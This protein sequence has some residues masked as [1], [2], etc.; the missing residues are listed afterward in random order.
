[1]VTQS[2]SSE[3]SLPVIQRGLYRLVEGKVQMNT[4]QISGRIEYKFINNTK[5]VY[6]EE[7]GT[8]CDDYGGGYNLIAKV[9][10]KSLGLNYQNAELIFEFSPA[11]KGNIW[12]DELNCTGDEQ[13]IEQCPAG[14]H[15]G[16][17][18]CTHVEDAGI[19][20]KD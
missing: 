2:I 14:K 8:V 15:V 17:N 13:H 18:E 6:K 16:D 7:W 12:L 3:Y 1:M 4:M 10:C 20:C 11:G 9:A 5:A 19:I